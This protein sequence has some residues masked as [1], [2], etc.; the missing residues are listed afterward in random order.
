[1][2]A[3]LKFKSITTDKPRQFEPCYVAKNGI[4]SAGILWWDGEW[5]NDVSVSHRS[6]TVRQDWT[7]W[8]SALDVRIEKRA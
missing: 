5:V 1:M 3:I 8:A 2:I 6:S 4:V 7:A